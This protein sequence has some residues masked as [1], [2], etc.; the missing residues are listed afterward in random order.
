A[1]HRS[2]A[3]GGAGLRPRSTGGDQQ[4]GRGT[5]EEP[6]GGVLH[7]Q[8]IR[9]RKMSRSN[10]LT[11]RLALSGL[12]LVLLALAP[13]RAQAQG[14]AAIEKL[15]QMNKKALEDLDTLEWDAAKRTLLE[16][17]VAGKKAGLEN[18]PIMARTYVH[19]GAVY[20]LGFKDRQKGTQSFV[21]ALEIDPGIKLSRNMATPE[22]D[23]AFAEAAKQGRRGGSGVVTPAQPPSGR[24]RG[25]IMMDTESSSPPRRAEAAAEEESG[26][27]DLP[28]RVSTLDCPNRDEAPPD[29]SV[30]LRCAVA[31]NLPVAKVFL[32]YRE[33][34]K[35][36]FT[37]V[38]MQ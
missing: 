24:R 30:T 37:A 22:L 19:L 11:T 14:Q 26:E 28:L 1:R 35:E 16:A 38:E 36:E 3:H 15:V 32:L 17:L 9:G 12:A 5:G 18:H 6:T 4:D 20:I 2:R 27:P 25:P 10:L 8:A 13:G 31:P 7:H 23:E 34:G 21:R 33:P 29:R